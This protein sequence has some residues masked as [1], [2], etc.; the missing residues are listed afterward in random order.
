MRRPLR[1]RGALGIRRLLLGLGRK[2]ALAGVLRRL[3]GREGSWREARDLGGLGLVCRGHLLLRVGRIGV[4]LGGGLLGLVLGRLLGMAWV[5]VLLGLRLRSGLLLRLVG[6]I[7]VL[8]LLNRRLRRGR[9]R[10]G[11][12]RHCRG[13]V[14]VGCRRRCARG[15]NGKAHAVGKGGMCWRRRRVLG[16]G[17]GSCGRRREVEHRS[18]PWV[19]RCSGVG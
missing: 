1:V 10:C 8:L 4:L 7:L 9:N 15:R 5:G 13:A 12:I 19:R 11:S 2:V 16:F 17:R 3:R 6:G 18:R 14:C